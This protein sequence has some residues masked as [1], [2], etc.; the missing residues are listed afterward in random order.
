[1][2]ATRVT[3][4][5][6]IYRTHKKM[7]RDICTIVLAFRLR[8]AGVV[9]SWTR[10]SVALDIPDQRTSLEPASHTTVECRHSYRQSTLKTK[11]PIVTIVHVGKT[12]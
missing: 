9:L 4:V 6:N 11:S 5:V 10:E 12:V 2:T 3:W 7:L 8:V 1:M